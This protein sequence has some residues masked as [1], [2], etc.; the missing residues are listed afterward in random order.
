LQRKGRDFLLPEEINGTDPVVGPEAV[1]AAG[2]GNDAMLLQSQEYKMADIL[3]A[4]T[5]RRISLIYVH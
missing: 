3:Y 2:T 4:G 5:P 1:L